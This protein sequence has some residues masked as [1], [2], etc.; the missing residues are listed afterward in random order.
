MHLLGNV[1]NLNK[2]IK[3]ESHACGDFGIFVNLYEFSGVI[4]INLKHGVFREE[5]VLENIFYRQ[6][7]IRVRLRIERLS[8]LAKPQNLLLYYALFEPSWDYLC[9]FIIYKGNM[10]VFNQEDA[11]L[12]SVH[13]AAELRVAVVEVE[14][15]LLN[16]DDLVQLLLVHKPKTAVDEDVN[17]LHQNCKH[18]DEVEA[19]R[20]RGLFYS[21]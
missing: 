6:K 12:N 19:L 18:V 4:K 3:L 15:L 17:K 5:V 8:L 7:V 1:Y 14:L 16:L 9:A 2:L 10:A 20:N 11:D 13:D 21:L